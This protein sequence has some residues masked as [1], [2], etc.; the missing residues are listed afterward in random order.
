M[1]KIRAFLLSP[2][3]LC[4]RT[5]SAGCAALA[6]AAPERARAAPAPAAPGG[7]GPGRP[8]DAAVSAAGSTGLA[9]RRGCRPRAPRPWSTRSVRASRSRAGFS[10]IEAQTYLYYME[11][12]QHVSIPAQNRWVPY[13]EK[14]E[15]TMLA[16][17]Q[18]AVGDELP[19]RPLDRD[20]RLHVL[21]RRDRQGRSSTTWRSASASRSSTTSARS[22]SS[23]R[24][25]TKS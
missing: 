16:R 25:S 8:A 24:R 10:V 11:I 5:W 6:A 19:R 12:T 4:V 18:A 21:E 9:P 17:L 23:S 22:R 14:T 7:A 20:V 2:W 13:T 1:L 15:Q 3:P